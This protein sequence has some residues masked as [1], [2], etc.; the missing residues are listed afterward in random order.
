MGQGFI[1]NIDKLFEEW[2]PQ[3][4]FRVVKVDDSTL[5]NNY[6]KDPISLTPEFIKEIQSI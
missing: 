4:R 5:P 6:I 1:D 3:P 2:E